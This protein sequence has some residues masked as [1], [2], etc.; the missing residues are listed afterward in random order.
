[1][2]APT[3]A[4]VLSAATAQL[5]MHDSARLDAELLLAHVLEQSRS[6]LIAWPERT[7]TEEQAQAFAALV[8]RR[9]SGEPVARILG[10]KEFWSLDLEVTP[11]TLIP[12]PETELLVELAL[13]RIPADSAMDIVDLGTGSGAIALAI[14]RE[15]PHSRIVASDISA[16]ALAVAERNA[17]CLGVH[18]V[19][20]V[21]GMWYQPL[22]GSRFGMILC[23]PPYVRAGDPHLHEG[24]VRFDPRS[25]L[26]AG[27]DGL[28]DLRQ[29]VAH[30]PDHLRPEGWLLVEHGYDQGN[31]VAD[32]FALAG[33]SAV[34]T[35]RDL[36]G[37]PRVT[38]GRR[39]LQ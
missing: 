33:F 36:S 5:A 2:S 29:I 8:A 11:D 30:A 38:L 19:R 25:A 35:V 14:A 1:M 4:D 31:A 6:H 10:R 26:V 32:L 23:N 34:E 13:A 27:H 17:R 24:D 37:Q 39:E 22:G 12:R 20:F 18:N 9:A 7:L 21:Q 16:D 3:F 28:D 15:R